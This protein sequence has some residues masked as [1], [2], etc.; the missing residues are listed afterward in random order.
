MG[1][2]RA[3]HATHIYSKKLTL[4]FADQRLSSV[5]IVRL[6]T[7]INGV[8]FFVSLKI[9]IYIKQQFVFSGEI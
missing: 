5:G 4:K 6:R 9:V 8:G 7:N 3:H 1:N 2:R